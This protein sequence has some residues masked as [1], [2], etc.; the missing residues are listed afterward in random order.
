MALPGQE[1][2]CEVDLHEGEPR[3]DPP[4][5]VSASTTFIVASL[6]PFMSSLEE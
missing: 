2:E 3:S 5:P 1:V 6:A 4:I